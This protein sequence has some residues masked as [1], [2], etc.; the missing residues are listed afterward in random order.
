M[1]S[2]APSAEPPLRAQR[3][4][5]RAR[6]AL[7]LGAL[8]LLGGCRIG[9]LFSAKRPNAADHP[10][11]PLAP[12]VAVPT[13]LERTSGNEQ[14]GTVGTALREPYVVLVRDAEGQP[15]A[16]V[17]VRWETEGTAGSIAPE[18]TTTD[19]NGLANATHTLGTRAGEQRVT[20]VVVDAPSLRATFTALAVAGDVATITFRTQPSDTERSRP[21]NPAVQVGVEDQY[22]N[23][24]SG[25]RG[26]VSL[27]LVVLVGSRQ[28]KLQGTVKRNPVDGVV[29]FNDVRVN[30]E[31]DAFRLRA[32]AGGLTTESVTFEVDD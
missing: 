4:L 11:A 5:R 10:E 32:T 26:A 17:R 13:S 2:R 25:A 23:P 1:G 8:A 28:A 20:A 14:S 22:G 29:T 18:N 12:P 31:G 30:R 24:V 19:A 15:L 16:G 21:F 6:P 7:V 27:S 9:E 3:R